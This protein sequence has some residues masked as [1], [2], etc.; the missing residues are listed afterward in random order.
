[1]N[2][3]VT[4]FGV[5]NCSIFD[6]EAFLIM[7]CK[8]CKVEKHHS[9]FTDQWNKKAEKYY[10]RL[11]CKECCAKAEM[12][13][14]REK[15]GERY[16]TRKYNRKAQNSTTAPKKI[17]KVKFDLGEKYEAPK[18]KYKCIPIDEAYKFC[19]V[20]NQIKYKVEFQG[21]KR[22]KMYSNCFACN[23]AIEKI[24]RQKEV[25]QNGGTQSYLP[26]PN[27]YKSAQQKKAVFDIMFSLGWQFKE[28]IWYKDGIKTDKGIFINIKPDVK[29]SNNK[30]I[31]KIKTQENIQYMK[32]LRKD[33][34]LVEEIAEMY[35]I[36]KNAVVRWTNK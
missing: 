8:T 27:E 33:G 26:N 9:N 12:D 20:C 11:H 30:S 35:G 6:A 28:G 23:S 31:S 2:D 1:M 32:K 17:D 25:E 18:R 34:F 36:G 15:N 7:I 13:K 24:K 5:F 21:P 22:T 29:V 14:R 3:F 10:K 16:S 4:S 19:K